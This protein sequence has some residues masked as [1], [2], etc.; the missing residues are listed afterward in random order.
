MPRQK[1]KG[2]EMEKILIISLKF[3]NYNFLN[4]FFLRKEYQNDLNLCFVPIFISEFGK[5]ISILTI[6]LRNALL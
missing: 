2:K 6:I 5:H 1:K 3:S 4:K